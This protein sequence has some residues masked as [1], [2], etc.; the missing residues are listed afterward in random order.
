VSEAP[1]WLRRQLFERRIVML[2]GPVDA[3]VA[4]D[5]AAQLAALDARGA[6]PIDLHLDSGDG[7]LEAAFV[8][9]DAI[10]ATRA[11]VRVLCRGQVGGPALGIVAAGAHRA[12]MPHARFRL[13]QPRARF[14]GTPDE[15]AG[16][17][18]RQQDLLWRFYAR[19]ARVTGRPAE[20]IAEDIRRG[21]FLDATEAHA[22][23]LIDEIR[24]R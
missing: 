21:R 4:T 23:G 20:E 24:A 13:G 1:D 2:T 19:L 12:A 6:A 10:D 15:I 16:A 9:V 5:V 14:A 3:A 18:R 11:P 7:A 17:S 22:Y 8:V